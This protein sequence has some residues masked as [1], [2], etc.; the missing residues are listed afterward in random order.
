MRVRL[1]TIIDF[2]SA[3]ILSDG[4]DFEM[5]LEEITKIHF[6][7]YNLDTMFRNSSCGGETSNDNQFR[8]GKDDHQITRSSRM[9][10]KK[11][12]PELDHSIQFQ[13][14]NE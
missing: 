6:Y 9:I 1:A 10:S 8:V 13:K 14:E 11:K 2:D 12:S 5:I 7:S 4:Y 3:T